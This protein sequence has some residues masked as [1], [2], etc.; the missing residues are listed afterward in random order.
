MTSV[1]PARA[2]QVEERPTATA[3][4]SNSRCAASTKARIHYGKAISWIV[5]D[6]TTKTAKR[7]SATVEENVDH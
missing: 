5:H 3:A 2:A 1:V 7:S 6:K 4:I